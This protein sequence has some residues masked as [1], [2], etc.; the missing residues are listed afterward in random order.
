MKYIPIPAIQFFFDPDT[1][2]IFATFS[3]EKDKKSKF[4]TIILNKSLYLETDEMVLFPKGKL[5]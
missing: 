1:Q 3:I 4:I 2:R 5:N